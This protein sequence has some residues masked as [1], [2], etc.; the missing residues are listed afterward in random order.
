MNKEYEDKKILKKKMI[1]ATILI[2]SSWVFIALSYVFFGRV[3]GNLQVVA[4][5]VS[6]VALIMI[7]KLIKVNK[8]NYVYK[9]LRIV[10][11]IALILSGANAIQVIAIWFM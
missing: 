9:A 5:A 1:L 6:I 2:I 4:F 11:I 7:C 8:N 10:D 3:G